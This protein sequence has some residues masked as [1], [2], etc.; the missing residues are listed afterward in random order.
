[1]NIDLGHSPFGDAP[2]IPHIGWQTAGK[3]GNG[4]GMREHFF[5]DDEPYNR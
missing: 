3:R 1:M 5:V 4:G 2:T